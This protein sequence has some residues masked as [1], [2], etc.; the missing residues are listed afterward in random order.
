MVHTHQ[1]V[2]NSIAYTGNLKVNLLNVMLNPL[3]YLYAQQEW[4]LWTAIKFH[5]EH[6]L[7]MNNKFDGK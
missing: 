1:D 7:S 3:H 4:T 5:R 6:K 2:K